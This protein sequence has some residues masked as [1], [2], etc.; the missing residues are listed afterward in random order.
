MRTIKFSDRHS[1]RFSAIS[2]NKASEK[3]EVTT[4]KQSEKDAGRE[5][6][7]DSVAAQMSEEEKPNQ[8]VRFKS[9]KREKSIP[10][11]SAF[12]I[13]ISQKQPSESQCSL[14]LQS[15]TKKTDKS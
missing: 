7:A 6:D 11:A 1:F 2:N 4:I 10:K 14:K 15:V 5:D 12:S 3:V 8:S 9:Q 13:K